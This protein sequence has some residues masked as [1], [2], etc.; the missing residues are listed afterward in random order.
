MGTQ[1]IRQA[2]YRTVGG[3]KKEYIVPYRDKGLILQSQVK[4][5][6]YPAEKLLWDD[7][8]LLKKDSGLGN[9]KEVE[10]FPGSLIAEIRDTLGSPQVIEVNQNLAQI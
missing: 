6:F 1:V 5:L 9:E 4:S 10:Y 3:G 7:L 2:V 8:A